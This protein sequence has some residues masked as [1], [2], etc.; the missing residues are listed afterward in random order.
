MNLEQFFQA[1]GI[2]LTLIASD[3]T[4]ARL[5]VLNHRTAPACPLIYTVRMS[6]S[7]PL[8]WN[9]VVWEVGWGAYHGRDITGHT[10][11]DG[12]MLSNF[13]IELFISDQPHITAV[14][15]EKT[16]G[17]AQVL[18]FLIDDAV[19][20]PGAPPPVKEMGVLDKVLGGDIQLKTLQRI[21]KLIN[22][23]TQAHDKMV[24]DQ[25]DQFVV[26][27]PAKGYETTE[28]DMTEAR[29]QA[30]VTAGRNTAIQYFQTHPVLP[31]SGLGLDGD[32]ASLF[33]PD[34]TAKADRVATNLLGF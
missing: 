20:V 13:P 31:A 24:M 25:Y 10:I 8:L 4:D 6:M 34:F 16:V 12:G 7:F 32:M 26:H 15:G 22:T 30:L 28:F 2:E 5:L 3:T 9:E 18:G 27:L 29:R 21:S 33:P 14:M 17:T 23:L 19:P 1:T 11:V